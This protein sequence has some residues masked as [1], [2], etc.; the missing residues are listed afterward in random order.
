M[1]WQNVLAVAILVYGLGYGL[2]LLWKVWKNWTHVRSETGSFWKISICEGVVFFFTTMGFPDFILNTLVFHK[3]GWVEDKRL[4]G[5]LV[6]CSVLPGALIAFIYL[7]GKDTI[8]MATTL[9]CMA[10]IAAGSF[11]GARIISKLDGKTIRLVMGVTM[12][13]SMAALVLK[14]ILSS[15]A[16]G[17]AGSL[18]PV[19]LCIALPIVFAFGFINMF[20]V[21]LKP[22]AIA[23]FLLMGVSPMNTLVFVMA[24]SVASPMA[25][26]IQVMRS[27]LYHGKIGLAAITFGI[28]GALLG[29]AFTVALNATVLTVILLI[30]MA[31]TVVS[32]LKPETKEALEN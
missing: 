32:V 18:T 19:Q 30:I 8:D 15:G 23:L 7:W 4:P 17:T 2:L 31:L 3:C 22:P 24:M 26:G 14:L 5:T 12:I 29:A 28:V 16:V 20:G 25:G 1:K 27:G 10:A 9:L 11:T 21:P 6:V 13:F